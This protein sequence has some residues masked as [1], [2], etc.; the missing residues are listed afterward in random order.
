VITGA[1][2]SPD[3]KARFL[4]EGSEPMTSATPDAYAVF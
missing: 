2:L 4:N 3:L 1:A